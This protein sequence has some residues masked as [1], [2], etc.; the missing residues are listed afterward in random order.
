MNG[1]RE[2]IARWL[3]PAVF[4]ELQAKEQEVNRR[5]AEYISKLDPIE[6]LM[7]EFSGIFSKEFE[8]VEDQLNDAGRTTMAM[9]GWQQMKDP[10]FN[11][12]VD[13]I[14]D[15]QANETLK[16][17][18]VTPARIEYGRAQIS[19]MILMRREVRRLASL[20]QE[21][22]DRGKGDEFSSEITVE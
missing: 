20:Y 17:A 8:R 1:L 11:R 12:M 4:D 14:I 3:H 7:Q 18:P 21:L 22:L 15:T 9:W 16:K 13:W 5:V 2:K 10:S 6:I 19:G